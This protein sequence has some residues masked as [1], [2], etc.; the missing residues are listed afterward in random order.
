MSS[1]TDRLAELKRIEA[2]NE[3]I[4][5]KMD[6]I[7]RKVKRTSDTDELIALFEE[8]MDLSSQLAT[9]DA[10]IEKARKRKK[11]SARD[12]LLGTAAQQ[13]FVEALKSG[14]AG[15]VAKQMLSKKGKEIL[16]G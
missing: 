6:K 12:K 9:C 10:D 8:N 14:K 13:K 16:N 3:S 1:T 4:L 7:C 5:E 2:Y 11:M 15:K